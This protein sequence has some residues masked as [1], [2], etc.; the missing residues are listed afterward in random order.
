M[1]VM[2]QLNAR[3]RSSSIREKACSSQPRCSRESGTGLTGTSLG[4]S[5]VVA[6]GYLLVGSN[7]F[8]KSTNTYQASCAESIDILMRLARRREMSYIRVVHRYTEQFDWVSER[9]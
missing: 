4:M 5:G 7:C 9:Q 2:A 6:M 3:M 1:L 8:E